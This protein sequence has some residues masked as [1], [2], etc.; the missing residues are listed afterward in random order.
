[1]E[2][3]ANH[4]VRVDYKVPSTWPESKGQSSPTSK[5]DVAVVD[6]VDVEVVNVSVVV[7]V[8]V[9]RCHPVSLCESRDWLR[10]LV[11]YAK[12]PQIARSSG[13]ADHVCTAH[14]D[15]THG[16]SHAHSW[17]AQQPTQALALQK[18]SDD[19]G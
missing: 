8:H 11:R 1:M 19:V 15:D 6:L 5:G 2:R 14:A 18:L 4:T 17:H 9:V 10:T 12:R 7:L 16:I 13:M 3:I